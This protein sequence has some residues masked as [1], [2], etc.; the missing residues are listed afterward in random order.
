[1]IA[2]EAP[3]FFDKSSHSR[4]WVALFSSRKKRKLKI[5]K[6]SFQARPVF[7]FFLFFFFSFGYHSGIWGLFYSGIN[8]VLTVIRFKRISISYPFVIRSNALLKSRSKW[9]INHSNGLHKLS[10]RKK[11]ASAWRIATI[12][13]TVQTSTRTVPKLTMSVWRI[14]TSLFKRLLWI[15]EICAWHFGQLEL[16]RRKIT[17]N[18]SPQI[19]NILNLDQ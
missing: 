17:I 15:L 1:M 3:W 16:K 19:L 9:L 12:D 5:R 13:Q 4:L 2:C 11:S 7:S 14:V 6:N 10:V 8:T 18:F